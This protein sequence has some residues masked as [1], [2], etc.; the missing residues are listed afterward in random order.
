MNRLPRTTTWP[1][2]H[3]LIAA[4][5]ANLR[6]RCRANRAG[7]IDQIETATC[8][9]ALAFSSGGDRRSLN[10]NQP[11]L[12]LGYGANQRLARPAGRSDQRH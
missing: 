7:G 5:M 9:L 6:S 4:V 12:Q 11:G 3:R 1:R 10:G 2:D 8:A